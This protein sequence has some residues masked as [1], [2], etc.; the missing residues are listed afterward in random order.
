MRERRR[1]EIVIGIFLGG[2]LKKA[3]NFFHRFLFLTIFFSA[4]VEVSDFKSFGQFFLRRNDRA[5]KF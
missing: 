2:G 4:G 1:E 5:Q 3:R